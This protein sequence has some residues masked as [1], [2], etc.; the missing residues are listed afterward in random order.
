MT[1]A[2]EREQWI[3]VP[4]DTMASTN[5]TRGETQPSER[6]VEIKKEALNAEN[7]PE[8]EKTP[9]AEKKDAECTCPGCPVHPTLDRNI[10]ID[11]SIYEE[12]PRHRRRGRRYSTSPVRPYVDAEPFDLPPV[13]KSSAQLLSLVGTHDGVIELPYPARTSAYMN[14]FP[15]TQKA[16]NKYSWLFANGAED[17]FLSDSRNLMHH[18]DDDVYSNGPY[19]VVVS[20][21][22]RNRDNYY[23]PINE[24]IPLVQF[25][26]ALDTAVVP[27][28]GA[29]KDL[30]Y[31]I[32]VQN[33]ASPKGT[34][35]LVAESRKAAGMFIYYEALNG[36]SIVFVGAVVQQPKK[37]V[38]LK[39]KKVDNLEE[40]LQM[41]ESG[42]DVIGIVC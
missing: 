35:L 13:V 7:K 3:I 23:D 18:D 15:F 21:N 14:T 32:V 10:T 24:D 8:G 22:R 41:K 17:V 2:T 6:Q 29:D 28:E 11:S 34:K 38:A 33:K 37:G 36:H 4:S 16:V 40:A 1:P 25:S 20:R 30:R 12:R 26:R 27:E 9:A 42:E 19:P 39:V 31:W 5:D